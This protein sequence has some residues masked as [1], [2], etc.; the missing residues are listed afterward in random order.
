M[1]TGV[2]RR[3]GRST[4]PSTPSA[5]SSTPALPPAADLQGLEGRGT[6]D[7]R[8]DLRAP[9]RR[10]RRPAERQRCESRPPVST[11]SRALGD[12]PRAPS[13]TP[14]PP[15][16]TRGQRCGSPSRPSSRRRSRSSLYVAVCGRRD[17]VMPRNVQKDPEASRAWVLK[18][19][20]MQ[21]GKVYYAKLARGRA[22]FVAP[23]LIA[24][25]HAIWGIRKSEEAARL[26]RRPPRI[27]RALPADPPDARRRRRA[28]PCCG[29]SGRCATPSR[30]D[31]A[32]HCARRRALRRPLAASP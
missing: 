21:R 2:A 6:D 24:H 26:T 27:V 25:F 23:R 30:G 20:V 28:R 7:G 17:A 18:D 8:R 32:G 19:E 15:T 3:R 12:T 4:A 1:C 22:M 13:A 11:A 10:P 29:T 16:R 31:A 14:V 5:S 9:A